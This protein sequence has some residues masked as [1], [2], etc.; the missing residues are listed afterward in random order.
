MA[1]PPKELPAPE[2]LACYERVVKALRE[3]GYGSFL[4]HEGEH[5]P[6]KA[7][8]PGTRVAA[9]L[10]ILQRARSAWARVLRDRRKAEHKVKGTPDRQVFNDAPRDSAR[11]ALRTAKAQLEIVQQV[12][13]EYAASV[14]EELFP[15]PVAERGER[16]IARGAGAASTMVGNLLEQLCSL[17]SS[18]DASTLREWDDLLTDF[19]IELHA[20]GVSDLRIA[21]I[22]LNRS[23][24]DAADVIY[25]RRRRRRAAPQPTPRAP[26]P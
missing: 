21:G 22:V 6:L 9:L 2:V 5:I 26:A 25:Q 23:D 1:T 7:A 12:L 17:E 3:E 20:V 19:A 10:S 4:S 16:A 8:E 15:A 18:N 13:D 24:K 14:E 11:D